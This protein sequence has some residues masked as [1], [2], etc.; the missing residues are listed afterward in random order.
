MDNWQH[1][2]LWLDDT[3][4]KLTHTLDTIEVVT[5]GEAQTYQINQAEKDSLFVEAS[6]LIDFQ[7]PLEL[8]CT[9]YVGT[10]KV[11]I[12]YSEQLSKE[13]SFSSICNWRQLSANTQ[14]IDKLLNQILRRR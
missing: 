4:I 6:G 2:N 3:I 8:F 9:D 10:I 7:G 11:K 1:L 5:K 12:V 14:I 13:V